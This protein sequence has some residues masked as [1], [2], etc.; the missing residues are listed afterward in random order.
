M[1]E[2]RLTKKLNKLSVG[3]SDNSN[4]NLVICEKFEFKDQKFLFASTLPSLPVLNAR[5]E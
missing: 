2:N 3:K 5:S 1:G 4:L